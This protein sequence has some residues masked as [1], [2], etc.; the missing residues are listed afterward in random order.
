MWT[1]EHVDSVAHKQS[2]AN[3]PAYVRE[4]LRRLCNFQQQLPPDAFPV[5]APS[6]QIKSQRGNFQSGK[7]RLRA[8]K[9]MPSHSEN[10]QSQAFG[11][12]DWAV[13]PAAMKAN[14]RIRGLAKQIHQV[15]GTCAA[16]ITK[17]LAPGEYK[18]IHFLVLRSMIPPSSEKFLN[19]TES[20]NGK[21]P[22]KWPL[23]TDEST[24]WGEVPFDAKGACNP[25]V[26]PPSQV[27]AL[28][29]PLTAHRSPLTA[30]RSPLTAALFYC[31]GRDR[32]GCARGLDGGSG[33]GDRRA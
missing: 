19:G 8:A 10:R 12:N 3:E 21:S 24:H 9:P 26:V 20:S 13:L 32:D 4:S 5:R 6:V 27:R 18:T 23:P 7:Y 30:H 17:S 15:L 22:H 29:S 28:R 31:T 11:P 1:G 14:P 25:E 16:D 33:Q 2:L